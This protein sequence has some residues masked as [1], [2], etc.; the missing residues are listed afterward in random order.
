MKILSFDIGI[1]N[2]AFC[3]MESTDDKKVKILDWH[4]MNISGIPD[5]SMCKKKAK[6]YVFLTKS[7]S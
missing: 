4:V 7:I 3:L 1:I 6:S 5:C 2:M